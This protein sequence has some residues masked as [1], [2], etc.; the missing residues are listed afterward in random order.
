[1]QH[2]FVSLIIR[3]NLGLL[4]SLNMRNLILFGFVL[5]ALLGCEDERKSYTQIDDEIIRNYLEEKN[6]D[7][8]KHS[9]GLY[10]LIEKEGNGVYPTVY[11]DVEVLTLGYYTSGIVF[12]ENNRA[13]NGPLTSFYQ[14]WQIGLPL[15]SKGGKGKLFL[16]RQM[17]NGYDVMIFDV[18]LRNIW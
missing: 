15:F 9:S 7:A 6:I 8:E 12:Q 1:M 4:K 18:E 17:A 16:P 10:Y 2:I 13:V 14:G 5:I 11:D 3:Y